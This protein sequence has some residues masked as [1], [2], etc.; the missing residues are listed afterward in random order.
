MKTW[1]KSCFYCVDTNTELCIWLG[2]STDCDSDGDDNPGS[3]IL[4]QEQQSYLLYLCFKRKCLWRLVNS[5]TKGIV[6]VI[7]SWP[8]VKW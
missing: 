4:Q 7:S 3:P 6:I 2:D 1:I 5:D 8:S